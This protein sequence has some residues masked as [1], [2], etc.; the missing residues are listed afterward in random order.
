MAHESRYTIS[1]KGYLFYGDSEGWNS[2]DYDRWDDVVSLINAYGSE[3]GLEFEV[4]DNEYGVTWKNG[5]WY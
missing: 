4:K 3:D 5:E 1:Y 2:H